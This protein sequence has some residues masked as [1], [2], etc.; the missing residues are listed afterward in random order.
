MQAMPRFRTSDA[1]RRGSVSACTGVQADLLEGRGPTLLLRQRALAMRGRSEP[2]F[3]MIEMDCLD[4]T[5]G[6]KA[7]LISHSSDSINQII[8]FYYFCVSFPTFS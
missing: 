8:Y 6:K 1:A 5:N 7:N 2:L 3:S 4:M